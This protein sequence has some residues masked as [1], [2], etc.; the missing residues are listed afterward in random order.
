MEGANFTYTP[1]NNAAGA[2]SFTY[3]AAN[4]AG[5]M[6]PP[7]V[8][9]VTIEKTRSGVTYADTDA[10]TATAAQDLAEQG[11]F[12]G[13]KIGEKWY[14]EP[15]RT[16]SRGEF[17]A[18]TMETAG[19][20]V[21]DVTM[22][23]FCDDEAIPTWA[24]SYAAAGVAE[25]I[26]QGKPTENG[27]A[28]SCGAPIS[29]SEAATVLNRVLDLGDVELAV[30]YADR[31]AM[32][33]WAAQAVGNMEALNVLSTGSFGS[34]RLETAVTRADAARMLSAA[35]VLLRGEEKSGLLDWLQ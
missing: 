32:P 1:K 15:D 18:M 16:V 8:V 35:G 3:T 31:E 22:T 4:S 12:T 30:W 34:D 21:T 28:F 23:G 5:T 9:T 13:A 24:R 33:S 14:F 20:E 17:L 6:S 10:A 26:V 25:G 11:I 27:A 29:Y 7:A 2:D 19:I